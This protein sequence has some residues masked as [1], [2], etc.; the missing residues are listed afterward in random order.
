MFSFSGNK[1]DLVSLV[2]VSTN[3]AQRFA[4]KYNMPLFETS[5]KDEGKTDHVDSIFMTVAH[6]LKV[7]DR[8]SL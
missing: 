4:D 1:C 7:C 6:K 3:E 2:Q 5:A 8:L